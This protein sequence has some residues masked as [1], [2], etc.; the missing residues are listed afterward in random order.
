MEL[1][2]RRRVSLFGLWAGSLDPMQSEKSQDRREA[3]H[4][5][6]TAIA[7][8][9]PLAKAGAQEDQRAILVPPAFQPEGGSL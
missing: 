2:G 3:L 7:V 9:D 6:S 1:S 8:N 4:S 5:I